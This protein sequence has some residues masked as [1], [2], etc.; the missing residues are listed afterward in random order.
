MDELELYYHQV[1]QLWE[2]FCEAHKTLFELTGE[3]YLNLLD[4][5]LDKIEATVKLKEATIDYVGQ[6]ELTRQNIIAELNQKNLGHKEIKSV[7]D[8]LMTF[9]E[10]ENTKSVRILFN[11]N[12]LLIDIIE[13]LQAQNKK[14]QIFL[15]RAMH[16]I[17]EI[18]EGFSGKKQFSTYG[19][20]GQKHRL[21]AR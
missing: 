9:S 4:G 11:L 2:S 1:I 21:T 15:N 5:D 10:L 12:S 14:N 19:S 8:L 20:D 6:L 16:S 3:E 7:T 18:K 17:R 13:K